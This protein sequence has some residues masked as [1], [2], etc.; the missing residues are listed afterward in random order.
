MIEGDTIYVF[1][2]IREIDC[3]VYC[4]LLLALTGIN[5]FF[6][7]PVPF[8]RLTTVDTMPSGQCP[9]VRALKSIIHFEH[10]LS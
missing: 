4:H 7:G 2:Y 1:I 3:C 8:N 5:P 10:P 9:R 6:G